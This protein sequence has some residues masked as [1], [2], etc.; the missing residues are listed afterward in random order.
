MTS[1][2]ASIRPRPISVTSCSLSFCA[3]A[4]PSAA[5]VDGGD[6]LTARG[7]RGDGAGGEQEPSDE[8]GVLDH[9]DPSRFKERGGQTPADGVESPT[10]VGGAASVLRELLASV[11]PP[12]HPRPR[13]RTSWL[14]LSA[15]VLSAEVGA[16]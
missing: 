3:N 6:E 5:A 8:G 16:L 2:G 14:L 11:L 9:G 10:I 13:R 12:E 7:R 1:S 4:P 15:I